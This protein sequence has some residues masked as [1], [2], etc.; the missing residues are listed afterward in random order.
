MEVDAI[1]NGLPL[2]IMLISVTIEA[3]SPILLITLALDS[4]TV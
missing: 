4:V 3:N 2:E 1:A